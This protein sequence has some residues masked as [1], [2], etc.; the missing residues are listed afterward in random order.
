MELASVIIPVYN[1]GKYLDDCIRSVLQ[2]VYQRI[3]VILVDDGS[4]DNS[5]EICDQYSKTDERVSAIHKQNEGVS[6]ARNAGIEKAEGNYI[7]FLDSDD[8]LDPLFLLHGIQ[9]FSKYNIDI[10][11]CGRKRWANA[12]NIQIKAL[13]TAIHKPWNDLTEEELTLLYRNDY[14]SSC[15]SSIF[16]REIMTGVRFNPEMKFGEDLFFVADA[17]KKDGV[18]FASAYEEYYY[19]K[20]ENSITASIDEKKCNDAIR[21]Y[22]YLYSLIASKGFSENG[23]FV[24]YLDKRWETDYCSM[25]NMILMSD[26][27]IVKKHRMLKRLM[28]DAFLDARIFGNRS[29]SPMKTLIECEIGR[30]R[31]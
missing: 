31:R 14:L 21:V 6:S 1:S 22:R 12:G 8:W 10:Y 24:S 26:S 2:Q 15:T 19:R 9:L 4:T 18:L 30:L 11:M 17:M 25:E 13:P 3:E 23:V 29:L 16:R 5:G 27:S 28:S 20:V 7:V